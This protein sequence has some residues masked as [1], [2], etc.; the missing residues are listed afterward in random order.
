[1]VARRPSTTPV[2]WAIH[3][4]ER[5]D[6]LAIEEHHLEEHHE[7][8]DQHHLRQELEL[9]LAQRLEQRAQA[10]E[11]AHHQQEQERE[12]QAAEQARRLG[13]AGQVAQHHAHRRQHGVGEDRSP[14]ARTRPAASRRRSTARLA[15]RTSRSPVPSSS[16]A[17]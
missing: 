9:A 15:G 17:R 14:R 10:R 3:G 16:A 13:L 8:L 2:S 1:M 12:E 6:E 4:S 5:V 7:E 11:A